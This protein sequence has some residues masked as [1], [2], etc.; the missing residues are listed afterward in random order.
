[1]TGYLVPLDLEDPAKFAADFAERA[2][3]LLADPGKAREMGRAGRERAVNDFA[4]GAI[5]EQTSALYRS[6][7]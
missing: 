6:L 3:A 5:A 2:N 4:W 7:A 1:V